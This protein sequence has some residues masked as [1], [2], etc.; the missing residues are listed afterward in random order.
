MIAPGGQGGTQA[1]GIAPAHVDEDVGVLAGKLAH[2][3]PKGGT[4]KTAKDLLVITTG[5]TLLAGVLLIA[6]KASMFDYLAPS[7]TIGSGVR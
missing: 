1:S 4:V 6:V 5:L 7:Y 3:G 2:L